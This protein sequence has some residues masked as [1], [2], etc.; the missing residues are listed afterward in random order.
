MKTYLTEAEVAQALERLYA[1][2]LD[3]APAQG[4]IA[5]VGIRARG[6]VLARRLVERLAVDRPG[7]AV[8]FG[9]LDI[10]FYR[11]DLGR[12]HGAPLVRATEIPFSLDDAWVLLVDDVLHTGRSVRAALDA[13][14]DFGRP[15]VVR[16][17]VLLDRG[18]R[19]LPIAADIAGLYEP[20]PNDS[21]IHVKLKE[22]DGEEGVFIIKQT[23]P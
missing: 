22:S 14:R 4:P 12:R 15:R 8:Q 2:V 19:E 11:D 21:R 13:L 5:V 17:A 3:Q 23:Q 9:V 7:Q 1:A 18:G 16:L 6:E 20:V 10:T